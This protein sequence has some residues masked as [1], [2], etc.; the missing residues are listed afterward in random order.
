VIGGY[1]GLYL[2][3]LTVGVISFVVSLF[4]VSMWSHCTR[5]PTVPFNARAKRRLLWG[6]VTM[7]WVASAVSIALL[8]LPE[9]TRQP[10]MWLSSITHFHHVYEFNI[11]SW[12]GI[13]LL[14]FCGFS[15]VLFIRKFLNAAKMSIGLYQLDYFSEVHN[16][17]SGISVLQADMPLAFTSGFLHPRVYVTSGLL[18]QMTEQECDIV[19]RHELAHARH[20]DPLF[21][22][23]FSLFTAFFPRAIESRFNRAMALAMEQYADEAVLEKVQDGALISKTILKVVRLSKEHGARNAS[24]V[25]CHFIG[26]QLQQRILYLINEDKGRSF[27][28]SSFTILALGL[29]ASSALSV[30]L[31]HHTVEKLFTH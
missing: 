9:L 16:S 25:T 2:N 13:S 24:L 23:L 5:S 28:I 27:P 6:L 20:F 11:G 14:M 21:K 22:F 12:H 29:V 10:L 18:G 31:L 26:D 15:L 7:P 4:M 3:L 1:L 19:E 17:N 8:I 30:D